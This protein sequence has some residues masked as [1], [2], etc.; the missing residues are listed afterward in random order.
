MEFSAIEHVY[1]RTGRKTPYALCISLLFRRL[2]LD[3]E[4]LQERWST[5]YSS[6]GFSI[7]KAYALVLSMMFLSVAKKHRCC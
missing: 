1:Q 2:H 6:I 7:V 5:V 3:Y 4:L